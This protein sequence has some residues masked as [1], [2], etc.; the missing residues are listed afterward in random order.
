MAVSAERTTSSGL[1]ISQDGMP[2]IASAVPFAAWNS[3]SVEPGS[4]QVTR[5]PL[6]F[7][8]ALRDSMNFR[9]KLFAAG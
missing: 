5:T 1:A 7:T 6:A 4:T 2:L 8:S 9:T 3:L